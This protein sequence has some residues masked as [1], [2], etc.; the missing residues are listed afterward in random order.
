[1]KKVI[2]SIVVATL[3]IM[4]FNSCSDDSD[5]KTDDNKTPAKNIG[6]APK[7]IEQTPLEQ[8]ETLE[9]ADVTVKIFFKNRDLSGYEGYEDY[10]DNAPKISERENFRIEH[11]YTFCYDSE[12]F[13]NLQ[14]IGNGDAL[15]LQILQGKEVIFRKNNFELKGILK[16]T[17]KDFDLSTNPT[18]VILTQNDKIIFQGNIDAQPCM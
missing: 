8:P 12:I 11:K 13:D 7:T 14:F 15:N 2:S 6:S 1:M 4:L 3:T 16:L 9:P 17:E 10:E 5:K 18:S